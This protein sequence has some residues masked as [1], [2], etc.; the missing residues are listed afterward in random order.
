MLEKLPSWWRHCKETIQHLQA[1]AS[2]GFAGG[3]G[4][5]VGVGW[6]GLGGVAVSLPDL[7][8][9]PLSPPCVWVNNPCFLT[10]VHRFLFTEG[11]SPSQVDLT[12]PRGQKNRVCLT[13]VLPELDAGQGE[14]TQ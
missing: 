13:S 11:P 10:F 1:S 12:T 8:E 14:G 6:G 2:S 7:L 5:G 4:A 9:D 3:L